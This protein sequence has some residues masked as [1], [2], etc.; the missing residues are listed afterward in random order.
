MQRTEKSRE[1]SICKNPEARKGLVHLGN[2]KG[3]EW[4]EQFFT[5]QAVPQERRCQVRF[6]FGLFYP[7]KWNKQDRLE[8]I[9]MYLGE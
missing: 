1:N 4:L 6:F 3:P 8:N 2:K 5:L 7:M 9:R